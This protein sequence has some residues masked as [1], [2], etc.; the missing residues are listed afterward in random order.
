[1][2]RIRWWCSRCRE[3]IADGE[4]AAKDD[5]ARYWFGVEEMRDETAVLAW[6]EHLS[7]KNWLALTTWDLLI[8][9]AADELGRGARRR[10]A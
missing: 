7:R 2:D 3:T 5:A 1:M 6:T 4:G 10:A 8:A 9:H